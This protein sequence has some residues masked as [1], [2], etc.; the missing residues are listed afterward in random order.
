[1]EKDKGLRLKFRKTKKTGR[2]GVEVQN[3]TKQTHKVTSPCQYRS[4]RDPDSVY[5]AVSTLVPSPDLRELA[6]EFLAHMRLSLPV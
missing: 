3:D 1:M 2:Q 4:V 5:S 6:F